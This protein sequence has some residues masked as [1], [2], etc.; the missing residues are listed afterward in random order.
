VAIPT[1]F[2]HQPV[3][4]AAD[5]PHYGRVPLI[6]LLRCRPVDFHGFIDLPFDCSIAARGRRLLGGYA[7]RA[8]S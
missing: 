5:K 6:S 8:A 1:R 3:L 2:D 7:Q 4:S